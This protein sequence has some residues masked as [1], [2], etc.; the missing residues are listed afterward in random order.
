[1]SGPD[2]CRVIIRVYGA[3]TGRDYRTVSCPDYCPDYRG[4][5]CR[6]SCGVS[7]GEYPGDMSRVTG[8]DLRFYILD[9]RLLELRMPND[10]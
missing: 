2:L 5:S 3:V 4:D 10:E 6:E 1:M 9:W 7:S 8:G